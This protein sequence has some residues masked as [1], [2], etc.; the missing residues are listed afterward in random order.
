MQPHHRL[1]HRLK[2]AAAM[3]RWVCLA[4]LCLLEASC[5]P[6]FPPAGKIVPLKLDEPKAAALTFVTAIGAGDVN[7]A[8]AA[9]LGTD[10]QKRWALATASMVNGLL[11]FDKAMAARFGNA[12]GGT[13]ADMVNALNGLT[14]EPE[15]AIQNATVDAND[16]D[17]TAEL[18]AVSPIYA[19]RMAI[20]SRV[21]KVDG[22]WNVDLPRIFAEHPDLAAR[23]DSPDLAQLY[24]VGDAMRQLAVEIK[25]GRYKTVEEATTAADERTGD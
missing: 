25:A 3:G 22:V 20:A 10:R 4:A 18:Q 7:T 12:A 23:N 24:Q 19:Q 5:M 6:S 16:Q 14:I 9:A 15:E 2:H 13:H 11:S 17:G 21:K 1:Q 8:K